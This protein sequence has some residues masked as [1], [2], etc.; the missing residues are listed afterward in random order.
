MRAKNDHSQAAVSIALATA[1]AVALCGCGGEDK[2]KP[3]DQPTSQEDKL[4]GHLS[5]NPSDVE[6]HLALA[7]LYYDTDRPHRA[8]P[9]YQEVLKHR[10]DDPNVRTDLGTCF[11]RLGQLIKARDE[12]EY[13]LRNDPEHVQATFNLAVVSLFAGD[14]LRAAELWERV[15]SLAPGTPI[16]EDSQKH[17]A[18]AR[19][20]MSEET[21]E[22]APSSELEDP[23]E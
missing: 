19:L 7:N 12:Y 1:L 2:S 15:A 5:R 14:N 20:K 10:P 23:Q 9:A 3:A 21:G 6:A 22:N 18:E 4:V 13:V 8:V 17:A 11:K 16:A